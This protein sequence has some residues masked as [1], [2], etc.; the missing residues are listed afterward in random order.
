[1]TA[2]ESG[3]FLDNLT[4]SQDLHWTKA[5][6]QSIE[7]TLEFTANLTEQAY[8]TN[9]TNQLSFR[10]TQTENLSSSELG[11]GQYSNDLSLLSLLV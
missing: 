3:R 8:S 6:A 11:S 2:S 4:I 1:M 7:E 5:E 9:L 10:N